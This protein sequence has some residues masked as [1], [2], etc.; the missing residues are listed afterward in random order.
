MN[1]IARV[2][3]EN[4][5]SFD[6]LDVDLSKP[7]L[8][9]IAGKN[10]HGKSAMLDIV[11]WVIYD[12]CLRDKYE[13]KSILKRDTTAGFGRL[14]I[15]GDRPCTITRT[16]NKRGTEVTIELPA[17]TDYTFGT[18]TMT[19]A[20]IIEYLG[21]T[22]NEYVNTIAFCARDDVK[23]FYR[24]TDAERKDLFSSLLRLSIYDAA[25][26]RVRE[27][28]R[29]RERELRALEL[30]HNEKVSAVATHERVITGFREDTDKTVVQAAKSAFE[31]AQERLAEAAKVLRKVTTLFKGIEERH[32]EQMQKYV[33]KKE[34]YDEKEQEL[35][36]ALD[37]A[38]QS[39]RDAHRDAERKRKELAEFTGKCPTCGT[40]AKDAAKMKA[41]MKK[42]VERLTHIETAADV[43]QEIKQRAYDALQE[44]E[45]P[46][47]TSFNNA[48]SNRDKAERAV[49]SANSALLLATQHLTAV[50]QSARQKKVQI[51]KAEAALK[52]AKSN[53]DRSAGMLKRHATAMQDRQF[54]RDGFGDGGIRAFMIEN[55]L[56]QIAKH[57]TSRARQI[58]SPAPKITMSATT[59]LKSG[60]GVR[61]KISITADIPGLASSYVGASRGQKR[62]LDVC[63]V[64]GVRDYFI[65][66]NGCRFK[67][68]FVDE[69]FDALDA[70]GT[71]LIADML[72][73][74]AEQHPV[75]LISHNPEL[76][77][78]ADRVIN[79]LCDGKNS[80]I[81]DQ[82]T[83]PPKRAVV[84]AKK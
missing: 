30:A 22:F 8:T 32:V 72:H 65:E 47:A 28:C 73:D 62:R 58:M 81:V 38:K 7:G 4:L 34:R 23:S 6:A 11:T 61:E 41:A 18:D 25:E 44:P 29:D 52:L 51:E 13:G 45:E 49:E 63:Q 74:H 79:V 12:R 77:N 76:R 10:G 55:A 39:Y 21:V 15:T 67:Q 66:K 35:S 3:A 24:A 56:P 60:D 64:L 27:D 59:S 78:Y 82:V 37:E 2:Q 36:E 83:K 42:E 9:F 75:I 71:A 48:K 69:V 31:K 20:R 54:W 80:R 26:Q 53:R 84:K 16:V 17:G 70:D 43:E 46:D 14:T 50:N 40:P 19:D 1:I 5:F 33:E 68:L 57:I